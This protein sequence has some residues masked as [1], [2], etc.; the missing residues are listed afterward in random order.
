M[1][2]IAVGTTTNHLESFNRILKRIHLRKWQNGVRRLRVDVLL[3][4]LVISILPSIFQERRV[5]NKQAS[6]IAVLIRLL[7][8]AALLEQGRGSKPVPAVPKIA[9]LLPDNAR[10]ER[11]QVGLTLTSYSSRAL[12]IDTEATIYTIRLGFN[13]IAT[14][15]CHDFVD[16]G[17]ACKHIRG[18]LIILDTLHRRGTNI[19]PIPIP[20]S[21]HDVQVLQATMLTITIHPDLPTGKAAEKIEDI[22]SADDTCLKPE[23]DGD[24]AKDID[25]DNA[26]IATDASSDSES[27]SEEG[28]SGATLCATQNMAALREQA[29]SEYLDQRVTGL[30]P[31]ER[32]EVGYGYG[33]LTNLMSKIECV[34]N[35][36]SPPPLT[37]PHERLI[38]PNVPSMSDASILVTPSLKRKNLLPPSPEKAQKRQQSHAIH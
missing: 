25:D 17:E 9:Y 32:D 35:L 6:R 8:G 33:Q 1:L 34:L 20:N 30:S 26:S 10:D 16:R 4:S 7:P 22:L 19:L 2:G 31:E 28:P 18:S 3:H 37:H 23:P 36:P 27:D 24:D 13:G 14:C 29:V 21:L 38:H 5:N 12:A 11:G 15:I